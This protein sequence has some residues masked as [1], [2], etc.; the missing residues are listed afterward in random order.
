MWQRSDYTA[1]GSYIFASVFLSIAALFA[2][3]AGVRVLT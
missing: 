2:G 3:M 1:L